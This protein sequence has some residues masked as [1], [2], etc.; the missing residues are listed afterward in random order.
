MVAEEMA[1]RRA[2]LTQF[3]GYASL[4]IKAAAARISSVIPGHGRT[5][6]RKPAREAAHE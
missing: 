4:I 2:T 6:A 5:D 1:Q 3:M